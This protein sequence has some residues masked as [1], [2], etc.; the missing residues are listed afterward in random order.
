MEPRLLF[1][2]VQR[3]RRA[4]RERQQGL[5]KEECLQ[6][7]EVVLLGDRRRRKQTN[8]RKREQA[9]TLWCD[10]SIRTSWLGAGGGTTVGSSG[11]QQ[12][13]ITNSCWGVAGIGCMGAEPSG[14]QWAGEIVGRDIATLPLGEWVA[15]A[16]R[17]K[18]FLLEFLLLYVVT[19]Y[20]YISAFRYFESY[21]CCACTTLAS[22][23]LVERLGA[24]QSVWYIC[25]VIH[26]VFEVECF[27]KS[28]INFSRLYY[29]CP[30]GK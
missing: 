18:Q 20:C 5:Q 3:Q 2:G 27:E 6:Q 9:K 26:N 12:P 7:W 24:F 21:C 15:D 13:V 8:R 16:T 4:F 14:W 23:G 19:N 17:Q 29:P 10:G 25:P 11:L 30:P 28:D 22:I 1:G